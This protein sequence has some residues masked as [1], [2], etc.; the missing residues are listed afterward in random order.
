M[1]EFLHHHINWWSPDFWSIN[2]ISSKKTVNSLGPH[3]RTATS[4][5]NW[6]TARDGRPWRVRNAWNGL[7]C[8][9]KNWLPQAKVLV[10]D[11]GQRIRKDRLRCWV[12]CGITTGLNLIDI[13]LYMFEPLE[14]FLVFMNHPLSGGG[15]CPS[16]LW[17]PVLWHSHVQVLR[18]LGLYHTSKGSRKGRDIKG[19]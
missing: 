9:R 12:Y 3:P 2:S 1:E 5:R 7:P 15:H 19:Y 6:S 13:F 10:D 18:L 14:I 8:H 16:K 4:A 11:G 17:F